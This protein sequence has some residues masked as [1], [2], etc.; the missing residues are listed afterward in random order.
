[1]E[2]SKNQPDCIDDGFGNKWYK[3]ELGKNCG[4]HI[5]RP[6]KTQCWCENHIEWLDNYS[7]IDYKMGFSH[8]GWYYW[9]LLDN[10]C[11][12]PYKSHAEAKEK[13]IKYTEKQNEDSDY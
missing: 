9:D 6:G 10:F 8:A 2:N 13:F 7:P 3:C 4:L 11:Y 1:M 5:V 12:G